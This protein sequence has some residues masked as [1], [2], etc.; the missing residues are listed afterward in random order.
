MADAFPPRFAAAPAR[1]GTPAFAPPRGGGRSAARRAGDVWRTRP[2]EIWAFLK[3]E[4]ASFWFLNLYMFIEYVRPQQVYRSIDI[5]PWGLTFLVLALV[6]ALSEG[7]LARFPTVISGL[8]GF[9]SLVLVASS[10]TAFSTDASFDKFSVYLNWILVFVLTVNVV[11]TERRFFV[12]MLAYLLYSYKMSNHGARSWAEIGFGFRDWGATGTPGWFQNSGE[13]GIQMCVF[14]PLATGFVVAMWKHWGKWQ[15]L[16]FLSFP[17]TAVMSMIASSSR[18]AL[19]GGA[20]TMVW[21]VARSRHRFRVLVPA[22]LAVLLVIAVIPPE[23][24]ARFQSAGEDQTSTTRI[25]YWKHGLEIAADHPVLGIGFNNWLPYYKTYY[26][27]AGQLPHNIFIEAVAEM[28]YTGLFAFVLLIGATFVVNFKTRKVIRELPGDNAF[29]FQMAHG[30]DGALIGF[31]GSGFFVTVLYYPFFWINLSMTV[32]LH[33]CA[34]NKARET[35]AARPAGAPSGPVVPAHA[36]APPLPPRR[37]G[38][39]GYYRSVG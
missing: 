16:F 36:A 7:K 28:G 26:N 39:G 27:P 31:L 18:G 15:R 13:F 4:P 38:R 6:A 17:V 14:F 12:Y 8:L 34:L 23:Q 3:R 35:R 10:F 33:V 37:M 29:L 19:L 20:L 11:T 25:T 9:Y 21:M 30:L 22:A 2:R 5:L 32:A 1:A 24:K